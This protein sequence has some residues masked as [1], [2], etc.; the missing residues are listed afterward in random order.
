MLKKNDNKICEQIIEYYLFHKKIECIFNNG[1]NP[2]F[3]DI[4]NNILTKTINPYN[5][6]LEEN[7]CIIDNNWID[8]W[9]VYS[10]YEKAKS[11]FD[12]INIYDRNI[13]ILKELEEMSK[14]MIITNEINTEGLTPPPYMDNTFAGNEFCNKLYFL[15]LSFWGIF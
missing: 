2:F 11:Y 4:K 5:E 10:N 9:K 14:N 1:F 12:K 13:N 8:Y 15:L 3:E 6:I 7:L